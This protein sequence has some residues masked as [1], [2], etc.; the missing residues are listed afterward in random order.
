[1]KRS[2]RATLALLTAGAVSLSLAAVTGAAPPRSRTMAVNHMYNQRYCEYLIVTGALPTLSATI[3]NT[4]G[5]D[6]CPAA[7]WTAT[8]V[9][10]LKTEFGALRVVLN[11]P[12]YWLMERGSITLQSGSKD[13]LGTVRSFA[14]LRMRAV[15][16]VQVPIT[17]GVPGSS[18]YNEVTVNRRNTFV[19]SHRNPVHEL[20]APNGRVYVMQSYSQIVDPSLTLAQLP[21]LGSR[22]KLPPGWR[23]RTRWLSHDLA[24]ST[25]GEATVVQDDLQNTYQRER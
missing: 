18:P 10:A 23:Y 3:W 11:G 22:L 17:N 13:G 12:R 24:L 7:L 8:D 19:W 20:L 4:F 1:M 15:A 2:G 21:G 5:L 25:T 9:S 14:G 16:T 6:D